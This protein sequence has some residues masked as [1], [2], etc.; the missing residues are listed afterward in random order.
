MKKLSILQNYSLVSILKL[1][2]KIIY[3]LLDYLAIN[4]IHNRKLS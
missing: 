1:I 2:R 4:K 3:F